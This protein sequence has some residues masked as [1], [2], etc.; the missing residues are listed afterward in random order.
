MNIYEITANTDEIKIFP[1]S[2][3]EEITQNIRMIITTQ[4]FSVPMDRAF[5]INSAMLDQP[6]AAARAKLSAEIVAAV[7]KFEP[8]AAV[9]EVIFL[10]NETDG[11]LNIKIRFRIV[12]RNLRGHVG[13]ATK[14]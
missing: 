1:S 6:L 4:K 11:I 8:R 13:L 9:T 2:E 3:L 5:G 7:N 10:N 14:N 12:E